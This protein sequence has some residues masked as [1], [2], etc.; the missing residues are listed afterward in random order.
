MGDNNNKKYYVGF[1]LGG[2]KMFC[3]LFDQKF[4]PVATLRKKTK[5]EEGVSVGI[6]KMIDMIHEVLEEAHLDRNALGAIGIGSPGPLDLDRGIILEAPNL[7]WKNVAIKDSFEKK[8]KVPVA[9]ANDVD[10][11]TYGEYRFGA[12]QKAR[13]AVGVFPGTGIGGGCV[14]EGRLLRGKT[15]SCLEIGHMTIAPN[16]RLCGCGRRG[17]LETMS[18]RLAIAAECAMAAHRGEA[19]ALFKA[20]GTD[21][22]K[23]RS[24]VI[25]E[26]IREGDKAVERIVRQAAKHLGVAIGNVI[27]LLAPDVVV[28]GG[29]LIEAMKDIFLEEIQAAVEKRAMASFVKGV[30]IVPARLDDLATVMGAAALAAEL[31]RDG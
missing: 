22:A 5:T 13:C 11:G 16:G 30:S 27:N 9:V 31:N 1:D 20:A 18:S 19:P 29:G 24:G 21:I 2:T 3:V 23:M 7:G 8:F 25:A 26:A 15:G 14:Y 4:N 12:A 17:C 28:L 6:E 10:A